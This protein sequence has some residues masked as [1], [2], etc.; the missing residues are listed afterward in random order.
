MGKVKE[1]IE[2]IK[3]RENLTTSEVLT[4]YKEL[5]IMLDDEEKRENVLHEQK[6]KRVLLKD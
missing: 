4:K 1:L 5:A 3:K 6:N 2:D